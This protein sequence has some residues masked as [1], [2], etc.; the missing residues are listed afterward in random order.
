MPTT[1]GVVE[2]LY[3]YPVKSMRGESVG[4]ANIG[5]YGID[6]DRRLAFRR[7]GDT[8]GFPWLT[9]GKLAQLLL[10][11]PQREGGAPDDALPAAVRTPDGTTFPVFS[12]ELAA[13]VERRYGSPVQMMQL[14]QGTFDAATVSVISTTTVDEIGRLSERAVDM[15]QFRPNVVLRMQQPVPFGEDD[16][17]GGTLTF[18]ED[19]DA[20][21]VSVTMRD[22]RCA[23]IGLD[24]DSAQASPQVLK[25]VV[26][27]NAGN[28]GVYGTVTGVGRI[29]VGQSVYFTR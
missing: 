28:A 12:A 23:M 19:A 9:A 1:I 4:R 26:R 25:A 17:I 3:R 13:D 29:A 11:E 20:P 10:F 6:G 7:A 18:G 2:A 14:T 16:W 5:W 15:R 8:S 24:V 27:A 21:V 22:P